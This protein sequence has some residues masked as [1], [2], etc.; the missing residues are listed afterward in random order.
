MNWKAWLHSLAAAAIGGAATGAMQ[1]LAT[2]TLDITTLKVAAIGALLPVLA[3]LKQ[4]PLPTPDTMT[5]AEI[6]AALKRIEP[7]Q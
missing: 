3:L 6:D 1:A 5:R 4:S 2:G 7:K